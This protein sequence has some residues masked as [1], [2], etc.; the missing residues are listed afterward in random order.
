ME[1]V[2]IEHN[3]DVTIEHKYRFV[4]TIIE[5]AIRKRAE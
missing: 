2:T 5:S 3:T 4:N 1:R